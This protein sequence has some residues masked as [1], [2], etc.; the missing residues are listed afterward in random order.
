MP[1]ENGSIRYR[2]V[3]RLADGAYS[4]PPANLK[5]REMSREV[6][7]DRGGSLRP[8]RPAMEKRVLT[9]GEVIKIL[10][11]VPVFS[12]QNADDKSMCATMVKG[13][14]TATYF[15]DVR[16]AEK[17]M[18][19]VKE[20]N[21]SM[22]LAMQMMPLGSALAHSEKWTKESQ[23]VS[24]RIQASTA[25]LNSLPGF[26]EL[27][28]ELKGAFNPLTSRF[29]IWVCQDMYTA[30]EM[31]LFLH[32]DDL[33]EAWR[34]K[35]GTELDE[36]KELDVTDLRVLVAKMCS[37]ANESWECVKLVIPKRTVEHANALKQAMLDNGDL[38]PPLAQGEDQG[39]DGEQATSA[40]GASQSAGGGGGGGGGKGKARAADEPLPEAPQEPEELQKP[41]ADGP[42]KRAN[43]TKASK[44]AAATAAAPV[45]DTSFARNTY[46]LGLLVVVSIAALACGIAFA[47]NSAGG[48]AVALDKE[49]IVDV[50]GAGA[51]SGSAAGAPAGAGEGMATPAA[52]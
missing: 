35:T 10:N 24:M 4:T 50:M 23:N 46:L 22:N 52:D 21:P 39:E 1:T 20:H 45:A 36:A 44:P 47:L 9:R 42:R 15:A 49:P 8:V 41:K 51:T 3:L 38:P 33:K 32:Q 29:P 19:V 6:A 14:P 17:F 11:S 7:R 5:A 34:K 12:I 37:Q 31:P 25:E 27:P 2:T 26:P 40:A 28:D 16:D 48:A 43:A 13:N 30:T 18:S